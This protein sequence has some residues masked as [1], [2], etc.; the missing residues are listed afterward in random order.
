M[1][2]DLGEGAR[3]TIAMNPSGPFA[4]INLR[5]FSRFMRVSRDAAL[6]K[7]RVRVKVI[8]CVTVTVKLRVLVRVL[9]KV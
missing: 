8:V 4:G 3:I 5:C 6:A 2:T 9:L 7:V 1:T